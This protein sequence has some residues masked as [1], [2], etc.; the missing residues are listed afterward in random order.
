MR[1][2]ASRADCTL[3]ESDDGTL[4]IISDDTKTA[5][6]LQPG[7]VLDVPPEHRL[8]AHLLHFFGTEGVTI[9]TRSR[10]PVGAGL[11]GSSALTVAVCGGLARWH[12]RSF[13]P[14][15]LIDLALNLEAQVIQIPTGTQDY[16]PAMYGGIAAIEMRPEGIRR[17]PL[18]VNPEELEAR[19]VLAYTGES[20]NS[21]VNNWAIMKN[22]IDGDR[23]LRIL[24]DAIIDVVIAMRQSLEV[25]DW[26]EVGHCLS[27]EW[28]LRKRLFPGV[29][30]SAID[31]LVARV[32]AVGARAAKIC[33]AGGGGCLL[34]FAEPDLVP[35]VRREI[36]IAG[37]SVLEFK[38]EIDGL[39]VQS[40]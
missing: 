31:A 2:S 37:A 22:Y 28:S 6:R 21:A 16:R 24:F 5:T 15:A 27:Q 9:H 8:V 26:Q 29:T 20:R 14:E 38:I 19:I 10:S 4:Q 25:R 11:A 35:V 33:G 3:T 12:N 7:S 39:R 1:P 17:V 36:T 18:L 34:V 32:L 23:E 13:A 30:T 40:N